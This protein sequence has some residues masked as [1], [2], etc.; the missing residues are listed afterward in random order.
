MVKE[1]ENKINKEY[2]YSNFIN[3]YVPKD[4]AYKVGNILKTINKN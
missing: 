4:K 3:K 1:I 2:D